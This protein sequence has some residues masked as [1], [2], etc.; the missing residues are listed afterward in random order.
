MIR[1]A[2]QYANQYEMIQKCNGLT[3]LLSQNKIFVLIIMLSF[4]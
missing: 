1:T 4:K 3:N 2:N